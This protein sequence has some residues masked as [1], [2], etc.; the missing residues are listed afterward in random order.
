MLRNYFIS[1]IQAENGCCIG[2]AGGLV[3]PGLMAAVFVRS[4]LLRETFPPAF[5]AFLLPGMA[6]TVLRGKA[7][8]KFWPASPCRFPVRTA[9]HAVEM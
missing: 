2:E 3:T 8:D 5:V 4:R 7:A 6:L 1:E 9:E